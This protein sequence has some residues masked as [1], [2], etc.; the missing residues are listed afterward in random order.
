MW[1]SSSFTT[2]ETQPGTESE[3]P[4]VGFLSHRVLGMEDVAQLPINLYQ[5]C[6]RS[7]NLS[8]RSDGSCPELV[9]P[10]VQRS[11][12]EV[13]YHLGDASAPGPSCL[14]PGSSATPSARRSPRQLCYQPPLRTFLQ[15][16]QELEPLLIST[17]TQ[18]PLDP[19]A[20]PDPA[21]LQYWASRPSTCFIPFFQRALPCPVRRV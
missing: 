9:R 6:P 19:P 13:P 11:W 17:S 3:I 4:E 16:L 18:S 20:G 12:V 2:S 10:Q 14:Y 21:C 5:P 8:V 7:R 15:L 1:H